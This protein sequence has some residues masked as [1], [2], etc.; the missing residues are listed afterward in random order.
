ML[1]HD[2]EISFHSTHSVVSLVV[3][4]YV[5]YDM[6]DSCVLIILIGHKSCSTISASLGNTVNG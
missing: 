6:Q 1:L 3:M 2:S 5:T 4:G